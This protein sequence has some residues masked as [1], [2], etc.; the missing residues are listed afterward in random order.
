MKQAN[1]QWAKTPQSERNQI[2]SHVFLD[3]NNRVV[4]LGAPLD[5][6]A[7]EKWVRKFDEGKSYIG[8]GAWD[9]NA[10]D[11]G[12]NAQSSAAHG[13]KDILIT[14]GDYDATPEAAR[15]QA[16]AVS[17]EH[18]GEHTEPERTP[19]HDGEHKEPGPSSAHAAVPLHH[20][21]ATS[22][23]R[24]PGVII[25]N[26]SKKHCEYYSYNNFW[27][28]NGTAGANFD[29]PMKSVALVPDASAFVSLPASFQGRVQR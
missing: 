20:E 26:K 9:G 1:E 25:T 21:Q 2:K 19:E 6:G 7:F 17:A 11:P 13:D 28:G 22:T 3:K 8:P 14:Y 10:N 15:T 29:H 23:S 16:K 5:I 18:S 4:R 12:D 27:N 24:G